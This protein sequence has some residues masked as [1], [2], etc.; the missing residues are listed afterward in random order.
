VKG[1]LV[2]TAAIK[3]F[4]VVNGMGMASRREMRDFCGVKKGGF[5]FFFNLMIIL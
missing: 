3:D 1:Y 2:A 5:S 4:L